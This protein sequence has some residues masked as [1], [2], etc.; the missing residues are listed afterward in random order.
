[1]FERFTKD[2]RQIVGRAVNEARFSGAPAVEAEHLLLALACG[3]GPAA[4]TLQGCGLDFDRVRS[5]IDEHFERTLATVGVDP[6][7]FDLPPAAPTTNPRFGASSKL[8]LERAVK[9]AA[10]RRDR[11]LGE[12]HV[13]LGVL[14]AEAGT[15]SR[16]LAA[17]GVDR[18]AVAARLEKQLAVG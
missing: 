15:V 10:E 16:V 4:R 7:V 2:A 13:L 8:V 17:E 1:M 18:A 5:A 9:A 11:R 12:E 14:R 6:G 3:S